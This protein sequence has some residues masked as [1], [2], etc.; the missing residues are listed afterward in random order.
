MRSGEVFT[1]H[2][3]SHKKQQCINHFAIFVSKT[4]MSQDQLVY[5]LELKDKSWGTNYNLHF[6]FFFR[7]EIVKCRLVGKVGVKL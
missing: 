2:H 5:M 1:S 4:S 6:T 7:V 3:Y